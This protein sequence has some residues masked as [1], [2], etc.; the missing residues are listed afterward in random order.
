VFTGGGLIF[1]GWLIWTLGAEYSPVLSG[2]LIG[3]LLANCELLMVLGN[4]AG[5]AIAL[6]MVAVWCFLRDRFVTAGILCLA[7]S[8]E[9]K[10][11]DTGLVWL[12]LLLAGRIYRKRALQSLLAAVA[13]SLPGLIWVWYTVPNWIQEMHANILAFSE[14]GG[15]TDPRFASAG[16]IGMGMMVNLQTVFSSFWS[17]PR[18]YDAASYLVFITLLLMWIITILRSRFSMTSAWIALAAISALTMLPVYHRQY[19]TK[20]LILTVPGCAVLWAERGIIGWLAVVLNFTG[21]LVT[22]DL[23][24]TA[25]LAVLSRVFS[26]T[27]G[28]A[29]SSLRNAQIYSVPVVLVLLGAFYLWVHI[30]RI[31]PTPDMKEAT[32]SS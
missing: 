3:F 6:C 20:L 32:P 14:P 28:L 30:R 7:F 4:S 19:D 18:I 2:L 26:G 9:F 31:E 23:S 10:P 11:H 5:I 16:G 21:F 25:V 13:L 15:L 29:E 22:G 8:L 12:Y 27:P 1:A 17:E 24:W